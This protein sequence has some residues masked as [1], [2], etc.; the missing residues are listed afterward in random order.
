MTELFV[1]VIQGRS[2]EA[3]A[4]LLLCV[5]AAG[6][7]GPAA[8]AAG[9]YP[10]FAEFANHE[11][12]AVRFAGDLQLPVDSLHAVTMTRGPRCRVPLVPRVLCPS[13]AVDRYRLDLTELSRDVARLQLYYRDH[14]YY[15]TRVVPDVDPV[16][17]D[18]VAVRFA[19]VPGDQV[20]LDELVI[21]GTEE[22]I[23]P[24]QLLRQIPLR[25][26]RP[27]RRVHFLSSADTIRGELLRRGYA[28]AEVLRNYQIDTVADFAGVEYVAIPGPLVRIDSVVVVGTNRLD[29]ATVRRMLTFRETDLLRATELNNSQRNIYGLGMVNFA[30]VEVAPDTLQATPLEDSTST[31]LVRVVEAPQYLVDAT[32]GY[33][34]VD[35]FRTGASWTNRNFLGGARRLE[36]SGNVSKVGVGWPADAGFE[37]SLCGALADDPF[38]DTLNYRI[39]ADFQQPRLFG[40]QNRLG[41]GVRALR[42]SELQAYMR[43]AV[44][45]QIAV[46]RDLTPRT[47]LSTTTDIERGSTRADPAVFCVAFDICSP[48]VFGELQRPR[49]SN[50][51]ATNLIHD[52]TTTEGVAVR[53][54]AA[55]TGVAWASPAFGSD[56]EFLRVNGEVLGH[57]ALRPGWV[58]AGRLQGGGFVLG[59]LD[60][61]GAFIPPDRRFYAGGPN[62]VRGFG[63]NALGPIVYVAQPAPDVRRMDPGPGEWGINAE[64]DTIARP[65]SSATGGTRVVVGSVEVRTPSPVFSEIMRLGFFV[66]GG[67]VWAPET[68]DVVPPLRLTPGLGL[69]F[70]TPVGPIRVDAAYNPYGIQQGRLFLVDEQ[71]NLRR[72]SRD[73]P[74]P[75]LDEAVIPRRFRDRI[76]IHFAVG[77]AF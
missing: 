43:Q 54:W 62:S 2:R 41:V 13:F 52:R 18:R 68:R 33:G 42:A 23:P 21:T 69:R 75:V 20:I 60:P 71:N 17:T 72:R 7:C 28:N 26:A 77:N 56:D 38:S 70:I 35:C 39:G 65:R 4:V 59:G 44:G 31:V 34:T 25:E 27:F 32:A 30:S 47:L 76:Q 49:W 45:G 15:A 58:L 50:A 66:D 55:R 8:V 11:V 10:R 36:V 73:F 14:G 46:S 9:P 12:A 6:A 67:Q 53:G 19:I 16:R 57:R 1:R 29:A 63:R 22:I 48:E 24:E 5:A 40:T 61:R 64:G 51:L 3:L 37:R 74:D